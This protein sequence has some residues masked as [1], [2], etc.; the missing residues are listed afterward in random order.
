MGVAHHLLY[1]YL[2]ALPSGDRR[3][4]LNTMSRTRLPSRL[5]GSNI[6]FDGILSIGCGFS[7][8][9]KASASSVL[10]VDVMRGSVG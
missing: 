1:Y 3:K 8:N 7:F 10:L 2:L 5:Q 6:P 4:R 9:H